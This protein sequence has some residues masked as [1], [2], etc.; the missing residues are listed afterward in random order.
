MHGWYVKVVERL[1]L[2]LDDVTTSIDRPRVALLIRHWQ[3]PP[4]VD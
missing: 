1:G 4:V 2:D 3:A